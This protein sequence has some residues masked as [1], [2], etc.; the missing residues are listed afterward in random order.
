LFVIGPFGGTSYGRMA[1]IIDGTSNT[2]LLGERT[3]GGEIFGKR[4]GWT[5]PAALK[6]AAVAG[7]GG[8]WGDALNGEHWI[9]GSP[10]GTL[11]PN[12]TALSQQ[13]ECAINC[14]NIRGKGFHSFHPSGCQFLMADA[15]VQFIKE[16][17]SPSAVAFRI[18]GQKQEAV[19]DE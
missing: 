6:A 5:A 9:S 4:V 17:A 16:S 10:H 13:G 11:P 19:I 2:F 1:D 12:A 3:G 15:S 7:N 18:T 14:T 8:G